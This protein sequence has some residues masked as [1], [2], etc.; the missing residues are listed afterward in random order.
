MGMHWEIMATVFRNQ[1]GTKTLSHK[2][3]QE[4]WGTV[5]FQELNQ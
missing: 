3:L 5:Q 1:W 2:N 4:E